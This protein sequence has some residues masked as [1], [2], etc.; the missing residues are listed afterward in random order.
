VFCFSNLLNNS[1]I[2]C[3]FVPLTPLSGALGK[4]GRDAFF[5]SQGVYYRLALF[6]RISETQHE[7]FSENQCMVFVPISD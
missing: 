4:G 2:G 3:A 5:A 1:F 6:Q 7:S